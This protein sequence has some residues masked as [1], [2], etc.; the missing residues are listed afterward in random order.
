MIRFSRFLAPLF[1]TLC[2]VTA[3]AAARPTPDSFA[4]LSEKLLPTVVNISTSLE[5]AQA[6][7]KR[8][9]IPQ[10][11]QGSP[12]EDLFKDFFEH[13]IPRQ[14]GKKKKSTSLGSGFILSKDGLIV[15]NNHVI[16]DASEI[17]VILNDDTVLEA[18]ILGRDPKTDLALLQV[19]PEKDLQPV[20]FGNSDKARVG[21]WVLAIGNPYGFGNTVTAGII[22]ARARDIQAGPYDDFIQTDA[23]IN[24]GNS[25][26]PLFDMTG[27]V[28]GINTAI[29][30]PS[31]GNVGIGFAIP[32]NMA[33]RIIA[34][35]KKYGKTRRGWIGV[36]IQSVSEEIADSLGLKE[37]AGALVA[38]IDPSSPAQK[39]ALRNGDIIL[40]FNGKKI[41]KMRDLPRL[42]AETDIGSVVPITVWR[43]G[44]KKKLTMTI[45]EMPSDEVADK[46]SPKKKTKRPAKTKETDI[47]A[48]DLTVAEITPQLKKR[49]KLEKD[50]EGVVITWIKNESDAREKG[51]AVGDLIVEVNLVPVTSA[52]DVAA[53]IKSAQKKGRKTVLLRVSGDYGMRFI[54]VEITD[55]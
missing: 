46:T 19:E 29:F 17:S 22:S 24:R 41:E 12:F 45:D 2:L 1:L 7:I 40:S 52:A 8:F 37:A 27:K 14:N 9:D 48:L 43:N 50:A 15:T 49:Y 11:P 55:K 4:D 25:G 54:A 42:V 31:G 21:D 23:A 38:S 39:S 35:L 53:Q 34:D 3:P 28:V 26:G 13:A 33:E 5:Q 32:A 10:F 20:T 16:E 30:S 18:T 47:E 51:L 36:M 6:P 44:K